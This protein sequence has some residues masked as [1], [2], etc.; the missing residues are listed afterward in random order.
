MAGTRA[1]MSLERGHVLRFCGH[2]GTVALK[3]AIRQ[4]THAR[5]LSNRTSCASNQ[6][7]TQ[8]AATKPSVAMGV[9]AAHVYDVTQHG[10]DHDGH[11]QRHSA[12]H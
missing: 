1:I 4:H 7:C 3:E 12:W 6:Q 8:S 9:F 2:C 10:V 11:T 5:A